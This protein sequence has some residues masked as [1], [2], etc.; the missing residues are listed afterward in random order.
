ML[1]GNTRRGRHAL[2][3]R[4]LPVLAARRPQRPLRQRLAE[5]HAGLAAGGKP[6]AVRQRSHGFRPPETTELY[7]LQRQQSVADLDSE[8]LDSV[9]LGWK[10]SSGKFSADHRA[11]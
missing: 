2:R 11:L 6:P 1:D 3:R 8:N 10:F 7:R 9:E 5:R 4:R